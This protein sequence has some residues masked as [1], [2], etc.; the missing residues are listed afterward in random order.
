[1]DAC[2]WRPLGVSAP[3]T[4]PGV[5]TY[6]LSARPLRGPMR[7]AGRKRLRLKFLTRGALIRLLVP[8]VLLCMPLV[9]AYFALIRMPGT[10]FRGD[11]PPVSLEQVTL[12]DQ[13]RA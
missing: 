11:P 4:S 1:M 7:H 5:G 3:A 10:S 9:W 6:Q 8:L 2:H 13:L 12:A